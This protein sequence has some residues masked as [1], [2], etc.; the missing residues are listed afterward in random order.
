MSGYCFLCGRF[1]L[2]DAVTKWCSG[3]WNA[4]KAAR[5]AGRHEEAV[6]MWPGLEQK[7]TSG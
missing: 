7:V 2:L 3:C 6:V 4:W 1:K 5:R